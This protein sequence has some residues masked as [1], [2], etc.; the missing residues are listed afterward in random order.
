MQKILLFCLAVAFIACNSKKENDKTDG[1]KMD[2][3]ETSTK[4]TNMS[5]YDVSSS[6]FV[7]GDSKNAE[8]VLALWKAFDD[9]QLDGIGAHIAD[10]MELHFAD[11]SMM[12]GPRDSAV[13]A[14]KQFRGMYSTV[15][16]TVHAIVALKN[17]VTNENW[18]DIWGT[19]VHTMNGKT[20]SLH[21]HEAWRFNNDGK[22]DRMY[23]FGAP[24]LPMK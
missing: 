4:I 22:A 1:D 17:T 2:N 5:G 15:K 9:N 14:A 7:I 3:K 16:S 23:Q 20:D 19:E 8:A 11:G 12:N 24:A 6:S 10:S 21:L 18:V 13:A